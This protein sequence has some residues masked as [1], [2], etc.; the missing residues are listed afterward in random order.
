[1][2]L[3]LMNMMME[4]G[5]VIGVVMEEEGVEGGVVVISVDVEEEDTM[6]LNLI[7]NK[8]EDTTKTCY[9]L[10]AVVFPYF[11]FLYVSFNWSFDW[12][13]QQC[14]GICRLWSLFILSLS[15]LGCPF[16]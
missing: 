13:I 14:R 8:M 2:A 6:D 10:K 3:W 5:T 12:P 7:Y 11:L 4:I 15:K 9:Q 1:M 16:L